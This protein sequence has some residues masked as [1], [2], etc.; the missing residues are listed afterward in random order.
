MAVPNATE[1]L[2]MTRPSYETEP[3]VEKGKPEAGRVVMFLKLSEMAIQFMETVNQFEAQG[4][5]SKS[6]YG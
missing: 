4:P 2:N 5:G 3:F 1:L 6:W